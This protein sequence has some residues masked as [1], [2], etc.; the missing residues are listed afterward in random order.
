MPTR[1]GSPREFY[2]PPLFLFLPS[3]DFRRREKERE[4]TII[5]K[6]TLKKL[7]IVDGDGD[8]DNIREDV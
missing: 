5:L 7:G 3:G 4:R 2:T 1:E 6:D 8:N